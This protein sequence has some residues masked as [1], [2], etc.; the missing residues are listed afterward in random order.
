MKRKGIIFIVSSPS[1]VGKTTVANAVIENNQDIKRSISF[2][3]RGLR[4]VEKNGEDYFFIN[5]EDFLELCKN[6]QMLEHAKVFTDHYGTSKQYVDH[7]INQGVDV[8][9]CIDWQGAVQIK[10]KVKA[11]TIFLLPPSM[12]EL[13][14]RLYKRNTDTEEVINNRI[15]IAQEEMKQYQVY[16]YV[17]IN[18]KLKVTIELV[19]SIIRSERERLLYN[20]ENVTEHIDNLLCTC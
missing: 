7:L 8:L 4:G 2:T 3:T 10:D 11:V 14:N 13:R 6:Q 9:C 17:I 12:K 18:D 15:M 20:K 16:D 19:T 1:G 5:K